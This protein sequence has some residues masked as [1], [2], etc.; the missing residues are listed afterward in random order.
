MDR[1]ERTDISNDDFYA[2]SSKLVK[3]VRE[4]T[5]PLL[6]RIDEFQPHR[7]TGMAA[8]AI[9][10]EAASEI[11][12]L[13]AKLAELLPWALMGAELLAASMPSAEDVEHALSMKARISAG[14]FGEM[15]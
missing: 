2:K 10:R 14:E 5:V 7:E 8:T 1:I 11:R 3:M 6:Q 15:P 4:V 12:E 13:E 9:L